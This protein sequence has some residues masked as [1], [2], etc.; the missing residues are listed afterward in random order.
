M[1]ILSL[2]LSASVL[3]TDEKVVAGHLRGDDLTAKKR[4]GG[5]LLGVTEAALKTHLTR[6]GHSHEGGPWPAIF[7]TSDYARGQEACLYMVVLVFIW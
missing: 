6:T 3:L 5:P 2:D 1:I 7:L 4:P